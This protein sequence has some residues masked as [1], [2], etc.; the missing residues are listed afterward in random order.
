MST[1]NSS[2][3]AVEKISENTEKENNVKEEIKGTKRPADEKT[4]EVKKQKKR[5][6]W[7]RRRNRG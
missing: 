5:R 1:K 2:E 6:K 7:G 4:E 3:V